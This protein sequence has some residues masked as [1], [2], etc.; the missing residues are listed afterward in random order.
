MGDKAF[1]ELQPIPSFLAKPLI[2]YW[3]FSSYLLTSEFIFLHQ[4]ASSSAKYSRSDECQQRTQIISSKAE[5]SLSPS[6]E[7]KALGVQEMF[8]VGTECHHAGHSRPK[9]RCQSRQMRV[10]KRPDLSPTNVTLEDTTDTSY[11]TLKP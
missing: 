8:P 2:R 9:Q 7:G 3:D 4:S 1:F 6:L 10:Q 11:A 5:G